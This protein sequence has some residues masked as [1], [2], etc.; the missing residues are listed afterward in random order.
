MAIALRSCKPAE[1]NIRANTL[2]SHIAG[3]GSP[4]SCI[5]TRDAT[6][7][8]ISGCFDGAQ[9]A[10]T[11]STQH[12]P[13]GGRRVCRARISSAHAPP[14]RSDV[15]S[16]TRISRYERG[17]TQKNRS[18]NGP[19]DRLDGGRVLAIPKIHGREYFA[20]RDYRRRQ[21]FRMRS[22]PRERCLVS[23]R[24]HERLGTRSL[25]ACP[26]RP[27]AAFPCAPR[28]QSSRRRA[29]QSL[30]LPFRES[31]DRKKSLRARYSESARRRR[32][33]GHIG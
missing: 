4:A 9:N 10:W 26:L 8:R 14:A 13:S 32:H 28:R 21:E 31:A 27:P 12:S 5:M 6:M 23:H 33:G 25:R 19:P 17:G 7:A 29:H 11:A 18:R 2:S 15:Q 30:S 1:S 22:A 16:S 24:P 3:I 20:D